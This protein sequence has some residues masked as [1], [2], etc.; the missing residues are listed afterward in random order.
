MKAYKQNNITGAE[1]P[2]GKNKMIKFKSL[3]AAVKITVKDALSDMRQGKEV[4]EGDC[5]YITTIDHENYFSS[6]Q[7]EPEEEHYY[8][9]F[10]VMS[11]VEYPES[12][13][14]YCDITMIDIF[15]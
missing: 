1:R 7:G 10:E 8:F 6:G 5:F 2:Q 15:K 4:G 11:E 9:E 3:P 14:L 12:K 13:D